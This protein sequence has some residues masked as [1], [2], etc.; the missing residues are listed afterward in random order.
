MQLVW[1]LLVGVVR[2]LLVVVMLLLLLLLAAVE[3]VLHVL[4]RRTPLVR[5]QLELARRLVEPDVVVV[6]L[7][8]LRRCPGHHGRR[9]RVG[10]AGVVGLGPRDRRGEA[11]RPNAAGAGAGAGVPAG[12][13]RDGSDE[14]GR[15]RGGGREKAAAV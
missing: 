12:S 7:V 5:Q 11:P 4:A 9:P 8:L 10:Q 13:P 3:L 15:W 6:L 2:L 14:R 1:R